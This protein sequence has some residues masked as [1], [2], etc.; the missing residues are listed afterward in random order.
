MRPVLGLIRLGINILQGWIKPAKMQILTIE[1]YA[2]MYCKAI[3]FDDQEIADEIALEPQPSK[4][5]ALGRGVRGFDN[6]K[7]N[8]Q[9]EKIVEEGNWWKFTQSKERNLKKMLLDTGDRLLVEASPSDRIWGVGYR[10]A[11]A[12]ANRGNWGENLLGKALMRVRDRL[13]AEEAKTT[14]VDGEKET[15]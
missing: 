8:A 3:V 4:Q 6:E 14:D 13:H 9:R 11:N 2:R 10:A 1:F 5:K 12:A 15:V 7:W